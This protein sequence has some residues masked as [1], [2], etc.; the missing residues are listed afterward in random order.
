[1]YID[2]VLN[3]TLLVAL[4][5][6]SGF[7]VQRWPAH[8]RR[9]AIA[10]GL[11]F[12][13]AAVLGMLRPVTL[14]PGLFF[15]GRSVVVSLCALYFGPWA[16]L[17]AGLVTIAGR[18]ALAGGG[19]VMG[20]LVVTS[21]AVIGVIAHERRRHD[22]VPPDARTLFLFGVVVH[23]VMLALFFVLPRH[24][25]L[26]ALGR[27]GV[28]VIVLYPLATILAGRILSDQQAAARSVAALRESVDRFQRTTRITFN[29]LWDLDLA[30]R[31]LWWNDVFYQVF[32]YAKE[33]AAQTL[34]FWQARIHP[35]DKSRVGA[36]LE[37]ALDGGHS[38]WSDE[39]RFRRADGSYAIVEDRAS[40]SRDEHGRA[41]RVH[42]ALQDIT[43]RRLA[44]SDLRLQS[45]ALNA[46]ANAI[47]I[48]DRD[49]TIV[50]A[51]PAFSTLT[52]YR[53]E[54][55]VGQNPRA[56]LKSGVHDDAF[57]AEMW[58]T[59]L[60]G[61]VWSGELT[62]RR[63]D[64]SHYT[65]QQTITPVRDLQGDITHFVA[66]KWDLTRQRELETQ[67]LQAQKMDSIGRLAG[68]VA[69]DFNNLLT[70]INGTA[71]LL[72]LQLD[73]GHPMGADVAQIRE[74]GDRA[75]SLTRQLLAFARKSPI[76]PVALDLGEVIGG[77]RGMLGR[78]LGE[79]VELVVNTNG[80][81]LAIR[82]DRGQIEQVVMNLV[83][84]ARDALPDGGRI[85]ID[86]R[87]ATSQEV[88]A[89][90][91]PADVRHVVLSV[92]DTGVGMDEDT[93]ARV[94][95]PFFTTKAVGRGTGLGLATVYAVVT[96]SGGQV[97]VESVPGHGSTFRVLLP[98]TNDGPL[99]GAENGAAGDMLPRGETTVLVVEDDGPLRQLAARILRGAGYRVLTAEDAEQALRI[100]DGHVERIHLML[101]DVVLPGLG[102]RDLAAKVERL[103]PQ[104]R[105]V[106]TS[107]FTDDARLRHDLAD[108]RIPFLP[109]PYTAEQLLQVVQRQLG[110]A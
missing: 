17:A 99:E 67:F 57:Y 100:A 12:G 21:S 65:E 20:V 45:A 66:I 83:V 92:T 9:G 109:K 95:E 64:G 27:I 34:E 86:A 29:A 16:A 44:E 63:K 81:P 71:E 32:G 18:A 42:G 82:A 49:G 101:T 104:T 11:L 52:G 69:H 72:A 26:A 80:S 91:L 87:D 78:L 33:P 110:A 94:F 37:F 105:I 30:T 50:W 28:P 70:I 19:L 40:I 41:T 8:T 38:H 10:Q 1:M 88:S 56:L 58:Q 31:S 47:V 103:H 6:V 2:L 13:G 96:Q 35:D 5:V 89:A 43:T 107:G 62:N 3:L 76:A 93:R 7:V 23:V 14:W 55:A 39:Y 54:E 48:T 59:L 85:T 24:D 60:A 25:A 102:G 15:D 90:L 108:G 106:F 68:G 84:N 22:E 75:A 46:T 74:A 79:H 53:V 61:R 98:S 97:Q 4:S 36:G 73:D 77:M 51:N